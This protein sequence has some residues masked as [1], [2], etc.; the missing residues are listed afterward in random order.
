MLAALTL[1]LA[2]SQPE[3]D[4]DASGQL[5]Y[6][7]IFALG[8]ALLGYGLTLARAGLLAAA[9]VNAANIA[10]HVYLRLFPAGDGV[11]LWWTALNVSL[12]TVA[13]IACVKMAI[14]PK[15]ST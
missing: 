10:V 5:A 12:S 8:T 4:P 9:A 14:R 13:A 3:G 1:L 15:A 6:F 11:E 2:M 7:L